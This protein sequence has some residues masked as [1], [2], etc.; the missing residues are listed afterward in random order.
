V[1]WT[2][3]PGVELSLIGRNLLDRSHPEIGSDAALREIERSL[4][5]RVRWKF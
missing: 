5:A 4:Q 3:R 1:G 2:I